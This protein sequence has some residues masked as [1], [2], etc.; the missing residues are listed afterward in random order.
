M[1]VTILDCTL[2]DGGYYNDWDFDPRLVE[3]YLTA[4]SAARPDAVEIGF[5][6]LSANR[7]LGPYAFTPEDILAG[8][9]LPPETLLAAMVNEADFP[10]DEVAMRKAVDTSF[11][12]CAE[13]RLDMVRIAVNRERVENAALLVA[14]F[15]RLGFR[16]G[17]NVMQ[18]AGASGSDLQDISRIAN[19]ASPDVLYFADSTG[20]LQ[21]DD[22]KHVVAGLR[23]HWSGPLGI[24]AHDNMQ[25]ALAN[26]QAAVAEGVEWV[27]GTVL[28]MGRGPGN[29]RTEHLFMAFEG[30]RTTQGDIAPLL[31]CIRD[32]FEPL[33]DHYRWGANP[34]YY[35]AG[36]HGIHP[37]YIQTMLADSRYA[38]E[39]I[40][41]TI[42]HLRDRQANRYSD[43]N[44][45]RAGNFYGAVPQG[46]WTPADLLSSREVLIL[47]SGPGCTH[48]R[49]AIERFI[50]AR[51]PVVIALNVH[52]PI[53]DELI[54]LHAAC[55]PIRL[56]RDAPHY[57]KLRGTLVTPVSALPPEVQRSLEQVDCNDFGL[58]L[59]DNGFDFGEVHATLPRP[60]AAAYALAISNSGRA[61]HIYMAGFDGYG[62]EDPRNIE[63]N[64]LLG[65]YY[66][67]VAAIELS[68]IT[69]TRYDLA[70]D[71]IYRL[72]TSPATPA[73]VTADP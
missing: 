41:A 68:A 2:R 38:T 21:P 19:T 18:I 66:T 22:I 25:M 29:A 56:L 23:S 69:P 72:I 33:R 71:S 35:L 55:H 20:S 43:A 31:E 30:Q 11:R 65:T 62:P 45:E 49:Q 34:Y 27:D 26:C 53:D 16:V 50:R 73:G 57:A 14:Q 48:H 67:A 70:E 64:E 32:W 44:L 5:R 6:F 15:K 12:A 8:I 24:H 10:D 7:Y 37:T 1:T 36:K 54:D 40:L 13:S 63:M 61:S 58:A 52:S 59:G 3:D 51:R 17:L 39:D 28:G 4:M 9:E 46:T 42:E 47:G 60:M